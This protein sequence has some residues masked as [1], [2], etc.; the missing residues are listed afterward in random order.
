MFY[1]FYTAATDLEISV[2]SKLTSLQKE[3]IGECAQRIVSLKEGRGDLFDIP[4]SVCYEINRLESLSSHTS[5]KKKV[6]LLNQSS[7]SLKSVDIGRFQ[8]D[9]T[10]IRNDFINLQGLVVWGN[11]DPVVTMVNTRLS[12]LTSLHIDTTLSFKAFANLDNELKC[13]QKLYIGVD[14]DN[15][16][17]EMLGIINLINKSPYLIELSLNYVEDVHELTECP[18]IKNIKYLKICPDNDDDDDDLSSYS[19]FLES[20]TGVID[21]TMELCGSRD[22]MLIL[23]EEWYLSSV[24]KVNIEHARENL[25]VYHVKQHFSDEAEINLFFDKCWYISDNDD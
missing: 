25:T 1:N 7:R 21:L 15:W 23:E 19:Q 24:K 22:W 2:S 12:V 6:I 8:D 16:D 13:L 11:M 4:T 20:C 17:C 10:L 18:P 14:Q 3:V 5:S 9:V